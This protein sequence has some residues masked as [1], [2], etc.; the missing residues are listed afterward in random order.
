[1]DYLYSYI[2]I[3]YL[4]YLYMV[5]INT[6]IHLIGQISEWAKPSQMLEETV[7]GEGPRS[8]RKFV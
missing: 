1:M 4:Y 5:Y 7:L 6:S 3:L 2:Y 8:L